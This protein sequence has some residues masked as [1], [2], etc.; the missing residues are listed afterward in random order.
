MTG[1]HALTHPTGTR[2]AGTANTRSPLAGTPL[3]GTMALLRHAVRLDRWKLLPWLLVIGIFPTVSYS[4]YG[5]LFSTPLEAKA[6][7]LSLGTNPAF[8]LLFG[9]ATDLGTAA[10]F[11]AWR[12][13]MFG[14]FFAALMAVFTVTRHTRAAEESGRAELLDSG[15]V[16]RH[17]RLASAVVLAWLA[18]AAVTVLVGL[19]LMVAGSPPA[20][21]FALGSAFGGM[22]LAFAGVAAVTAQLGSSGRT[23]NTL[24]ATVLGV[25]YLLRG[26]GDTLDDSQW[27]L[28]TSPMG[29]AEKIRPASENELRP[30]LLLLAAA[31]ALAVLAAWLE[32]RRDFGLGLIAPRG[33]PA[34]GR[35][36]TWGLTARLNRGA[37][38]TWAV[39]FVALGSV[40]GLVATTMSGIFRDN[41]FV[42][43]MI[44]FRLATE[45]QLLFA[46]VEVLL[47]V[48]AFIGGVFGI[49]VI[50]RFHT[51]EDEGRA[52]WLLSEPMSRLSYVV[53][54]IVLAAL[55]P[56]VGMAAGSAALATSARLAGSELDTAK[57]VFQGVAEVPAL[58]LAAAVALF[59]VGLAPRARAGAWLL[60]V[61]W[62]LLTMFGPVLKA[63]DWL[64]ST[65]P[66]HVVPN[67]MES[68]P[69]WLP[70]GWTL[71]LSAVLLVAGLA[72]Y[73]RRDL[74]SR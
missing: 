56:A 6:L 67:V 42:R 2:A 15:V 43:Q 24:A 38:L 35:L 11:T 68:S 39:V 53:P 18:S 49:Q 7:Q 45:E 36:G 60:L 61:Y 64:L 22:G 70:V 5:S 4:V 66:F 40:Y 29:W 12:V 21:A 46:F 62:L 63:P 16:G 57:V 34:R 72:G 65:S 54:T 37:F 28:W 10:G 27:L 20:P 30:L 48:L 47:L 73:R 17:A 51:E 23:A 58:W 55:G 69:D 52:E 59:L 50:L 9:P 13:Q 19:A 41:P 26:L 74:L 31:L 1:R 33:G 8:S 32:S 25:S 3:T 14:M 71:L 44:A